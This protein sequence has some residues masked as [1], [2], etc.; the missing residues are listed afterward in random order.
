MERLGHGIVNPVIIHDYD[1]RWPELFETLRSRIAGAL[2]S[3]AAAIE[4]VG[5]TAVPGLAA[6]PIIDMDVLLKSDADFP[7][8][9]A[10][11]ASIGYEHEGDLGIAGREA[12][13]SPPKTCEHHLYV[14]G[15]GSSAYAQHIAFRDYLRTHPQD[16]DAY[17]EL[18]RKLAGKFLDNRDA[19]TQA[20]S[21]FIVEILQRISDKRISGFR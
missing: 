17:A 21:G 11:L 3:M 19:Y 8:V 15:P 4:H 5:S 12:F 20:K 9:I 1:P 18:K 10:K 2:G 13:R 14:C 6:K 7:L 16:A